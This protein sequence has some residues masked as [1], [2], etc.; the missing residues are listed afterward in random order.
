MPQLTILLATMALMVVRHV[1]VTTDDQH[2]QQRIDE[3]SNQQGTL[4]VIFLVLF[5]LRFGLP[6]RVGVSDGEFPTRN[7]MPTSSSRRSAIRLRY[8]GVVMAE[9]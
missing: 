8:L 5:L 4:D 7:P 2:S 1:H 3:R 6:R 9:I